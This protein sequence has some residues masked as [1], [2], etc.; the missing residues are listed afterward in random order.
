MNYIFIITIVII[1]TINSVVGSKTKYYAVCVNTANYICPGNVGKLYFNGCND[2]ICGGPENY[3][4]ACT[5]NPCTLYF[6]TY[7]EYVRFCTII[8]NMKIR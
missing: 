3:V 6:V 5:T 8:R 1:G 2:C 4:G 7:D